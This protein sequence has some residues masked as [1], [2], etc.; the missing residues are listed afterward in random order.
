[1]DSNEDEWPDAEVVAEERSLVTVDR[2]ATAL[3]AQARATIQA[4][5][6]M[7]LERPRSLPRVRDIVLTQLK[8]PSLAARAVYAVPRGKKKDAEGKW[9]EN[10][11]EGPSIK[12]ANALRIAMGNLGTEDRV[13]ADDADYRTIEV[14]AIDYESNSSET[15]SVVVSKTV[16]RKGF[17]RGNTW[18]P[19]DR[20]II[21]SRQN[22]YGEPVFKCR[23][24]EAEIQEAQNSAASR[25]R[26]NAIIA[27]VPADIVDDA[28]RLAKQITASRAAEQRQAT[29]ERLKGVFAKG[30]TTQAELAEYLGRSIDE[31]TAEDLTGL[32]MLATGIAEGHTTWRAAVKARAEARAAEDAPDGADDPPAKEAPAKERGAAATRAAIDRATKGGGS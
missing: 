16:E 21:S 32:E 20:E 25:A 5:V 31:A 19:P 30:G 9:V 7:A 2:S 26:R 27:L 11:A 18:D 28:V 1:M 24:T 14:T 23:A 6:W 4:R 22:S 29:I 3:A 8:R 17:K 12:L 15:R 10:I 13:I